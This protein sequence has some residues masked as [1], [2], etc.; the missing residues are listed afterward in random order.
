M[1]PVTYR[2]KG[3]SAPPQLAINDYRRV[4][5]RPEHNLDQILD[6]RVI[7]RFFSRDWNAVVLQRGAIGVASRG[8]DILEHDHVFGFDLLPDGHDRSIARFSVQQNS[9]RVVSRSIETRAHT[10]QLPATK[11]VELCN[12]IILQA[13][14]QDL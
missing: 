8:H 13:V 9:A 12:N 6:I 7:R 10:R 5:R 11:R 2:R 1:L 14:F 4:G 3:T